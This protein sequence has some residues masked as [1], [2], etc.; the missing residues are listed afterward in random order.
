MFVNFGGSLQ[1]YCDRK[2]HR[3]ERNRIDGQKRNRWPTNGNMFLQ[4]FQQR[5]STERLRAQSRVAAKSRRERESRLFAEL[6]AWLP[7][8]A[9]LTVHMDKAS[10]VRFTL[11][12]LRLRAAID[13]RDISAPETSVRDTA[14]H[15]VHERQPLV[16]LCSEEIVLDS[17]LG[18]F[19]VLV[20]ENGQIIYATGDIH[21]HTGLDQ[22]DLI[23][24]SLFDFT[25]LC[26]QKEVQ[27]IFSKELAAE[28]IQKCDFLLRMKS[29][30]TSQGG[31]L[32]QKHTNWQAIHCS[33]VKK[34]CPYPETACLVLLC[35]P[36]PISQNMARD[37]SLNHRTFLSR[38]SPDMRFTYC[39]SGV[40]ELTGYAEREL[41]G[42]SVYQYYHAFDCQNIY[43]THQSLLSKGQAS[44]SRYRL[45]L[46]GGG[47]VW[48]ETDASVVYNQTRQPQS[49][50]CINYILSEVE[51]PEM[52]FSLQ[53]TEALLRPCYSGLGVGPTVQKKACP[54]AEHEDKIQTYAELKLEYQMNT[55][56]PSE[57]YELDLDSLAP[58]IPMDGE[59]FLLPP[60]ID[61]ISDMSGGKPPD[62][63]LVIPLG[64][65]DQSS[66]ITPADM[67]PQCRMNYVQIK[68]NRR[69][70]Q[71]SVF[72][73]CTQSGYRSGHRGYNEVTGLDRWEEPHLTERESDKYYASCRHL[74]G[75]VSAVRLPQRTFD[76]FPVHQPDV[77]TDLCGPRS[78]E[79]M[80]R[81]TQQPPEFSKAP[82]SPYNDTDKRSTWQTP[83]PLP[84]LSPLDCEGILGPTR[85][86]LQGSEITSVLDQATLRFSHLKALATDQL[87]TK[88]AHMYTPRSATKVN[89]GTSTLYA[90][91]IT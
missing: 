37:A 16:G 57:V 30:L 80:W 91:W 11:A 69:T 5:V 36:L 50:V 63:G 20:S 2:L 28:G 15:S 1:R 75:F 77:S 17:A 85:C 66:L 87:T 60:V 73:D 79:V 84:V 83:L 56:S 35:R 53:Q 25:H 34:K 45:L 7:E 86:L 10:I 74:C 4:D 9:G 78:R 49:I 21:T 76:C 59:D 61:G 55:N 26:D 62:N 29:T 82:Q 38:H 71:E 3:T 6:A 64:L 32:N 51:L 88:H 44:L 43:K 52:T 40:K 33:G 65:E 72:R 27:D 31:T 67:S 42:Q 54:T 39:Q 81:C 41:L 23:G 12:Y 68:Q 89:C 47:Y 48:A 22:M 70:V 58:Y 8:P 46:K 13:Q 14:Y 90:E 19:M 24:R 18:G